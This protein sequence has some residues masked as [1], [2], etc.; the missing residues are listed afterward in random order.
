M[1]RIETRE[2]LLEYAAEHAPAKACARAIRE[3][4]ASVLG[5]YRGIQPRGLDGWVIR[6]DSRH[7]RTWFVGVLEDRERHRLLVD[8]LDHYANAVYVGRLR[9]PGAGY[10]IFEG[11]RNESRDPV[12][13]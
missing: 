13:V 6:V 2:D 1:T 5:G 3:G 9:P 12:R 7:G 8:R 11:D 10:C 4:R